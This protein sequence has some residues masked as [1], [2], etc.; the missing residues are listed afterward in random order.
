[1][2]RYYVNIAPSL[3][4]MLQDPESDTQCPEG[5]RMIERFGPR[6]EQNEC[7]IV[8]D[9]NA[10][11]EFEDHLVMPSFRA[12]VNDMD[13]PDAGVTVTVYDREIV[14]AP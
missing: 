9:D 6:F 10:G 12:T 1:M 3:V 5:W 8:E 2:T 14:K 4:Q 13:D 11:P 7:W